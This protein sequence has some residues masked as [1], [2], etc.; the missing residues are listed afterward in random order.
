LLYDGKAEVVGNLLDEEE[1]D[2]ES[3]LLKLLLGRMSEL[4]GR[5][6]GFRRSFPSSRPSMVPTSQYIKRPVGVR[7]LRGSVGGRAML[8]RSLES[9]VELWR[10]GVLLTVVFQAVARVVLPRGSQPRLPVCNK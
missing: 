7:P 4:L 1:A 8:K 5:I 10:L 2:A 3:P 6:S 9:L